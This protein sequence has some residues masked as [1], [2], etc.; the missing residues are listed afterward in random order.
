M[1]CTPDVRH[2]ITDIWDEFPDTS[3]FLFLP[4]V[5]LCVIIYN[6]IINLII[7]MVIKNK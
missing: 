1:K 6:L 3:D 7:V 5:Y 4:F 2:N